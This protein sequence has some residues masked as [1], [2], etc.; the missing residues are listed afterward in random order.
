MIVYITGLGY[1]SSSVMEILSTARQSEYVW[2][3][4]TLGEPQQPCKP[5][6]SQ[7]GIH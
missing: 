2:V 7:S 4:N 1:A 3:N 6:L 5:L